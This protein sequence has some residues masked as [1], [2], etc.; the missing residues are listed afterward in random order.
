MN[1]NQAEHQK[2]NTDLALLGVMLSTITIET[3]EKALEDYETA[4]AGSTAFMTLVDRPFEWLR[5]V[6]DKRKVLK[7]ILELR[8]MSFVKDFEKLNEGGASQ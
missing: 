2:L 3:L 7:L 8:K 5:N 1:L 6:E 4:S